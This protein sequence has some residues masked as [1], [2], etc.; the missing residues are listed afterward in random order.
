VLIKKKK[1]LSPKKVIGRLPHNLRV[2]AVVGRLGVLPNATGLA[3]LAFK[4]AFS[5]GIAGRQCDE[6]MLLAI[7]AS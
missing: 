2:R 5:F 3:T 1:F 4:R 7:S 6:E